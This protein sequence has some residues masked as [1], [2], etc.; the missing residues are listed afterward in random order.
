[1]EL[2]VLFLLNM[3]IRA[4]NIKLILSW[5]RS[6]WPCPVYAER[7]CFTAITNHDDMTDIIRGCSTFDLEYQCNGFT[8]RDLDENGEIIKTTEWNACKGPDQKLL[9]S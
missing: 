2:V 1:M 4:H 6:I 9:F 5:S 8:E 3:K 7:G